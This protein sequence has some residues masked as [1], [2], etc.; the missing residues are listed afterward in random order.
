MFWRSISARIKVVVLI[1]VFLVSALVISAGAGTVFVDSPVNHAVSRISDWSNENQKAC[2]FTL[3][4]SA[5]TVTK[6]RWWGSYGASPDPAVDNFVFKFFVED[7]SNPGYPSTVCF[8]DGTRS[9]NSYS[10]SDF[11]RTAT[12]MVSDPSGSHDGGIV[13][14]YSAVLDAPIHLEGGTRY[15]LAITNST[16]TYAYPPQPNSKWGWLEST[17]G[18]QWYRL[19][20]CPEC[21]DDW[22]VSHSKNLAFA[23]ETFPTV[24]LCGN[25]AA[26]DHVISTASK[27]FLFAAWGKAKITGSDTFQLDDGSGVPISVKSLGFGGFSD[28]D[29]VRAM[30]LLSYS[31]GGS[32]LKADAADVVKM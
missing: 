5:Q 32:T 25:R 24:G 8:D 17:S 11:S 3:V 30:G 2:D 10:G 15:W 26:S 20:H 14:E 12:A 28:G 29:C 22:S 1:A 16:P 9:P 19:G 13:Y 21:A 23:L 7:P 4:G 27:G 18:S 6:I 31:A